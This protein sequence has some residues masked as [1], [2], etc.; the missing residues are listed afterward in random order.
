MKK[1]YYFTF[2]FKYSSKRLNRFLFF[3]WWFGTGLTWMLGLG[4]PS[5]SILV[6]IGPILLG[7]STFINE[8][9][10]TY[11]KDYEEKL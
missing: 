11:D 9:K 10:F 6:L 3:I 5:S 1:K 2:G 7:L 4:I 8:M